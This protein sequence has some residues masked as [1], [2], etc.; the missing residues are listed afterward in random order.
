MAADLKE[1][2]ELFDKDEDGSISF[3][4]Y[5]QATHAAGLHPTE[6]ELKAEFDK[7]DSS[8]LL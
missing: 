7:V 2:F 5:R 3:D 6:A 8:E 1:A 4:E